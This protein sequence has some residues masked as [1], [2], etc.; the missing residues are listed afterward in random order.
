MPS[1]TLP[2]GRANKV[3]PMNNYTIALV[4]N[5]GY[6]SGLSVWHL[7]LIFKNYLV[8]WHKKIIY[9]VKIKGV[10]RLHSEDSVSLLYMPGLLVCGSLTQAPGPHLGSRVS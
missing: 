2:S 3:M 10:I 9:M 5:Q 1:K 4:L 7:I 8:L 6:A